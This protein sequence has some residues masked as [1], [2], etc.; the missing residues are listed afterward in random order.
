M[1][2]RVD[3]ESSRNEADLARFISQTAFNVTIP[4]LGD[5]CTMGGDCVG[6]LESSSIVGSR[7]VTSIA[8]DRRDSIFVYLSP[9]ARISLNYLDPF[10]QFNGTGTPSLQTTKPLYVPRCFFNL[11]CRELTP[12]PFVLLPLE[13]LHR[14]RP[15]FRRI[16]SPRHG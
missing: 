5:K 13:L 7:V 3:D 2:E 8:A 1:K 12:L 14:L 16:T 15:T 9:L 10:I 4:D 11:S 6:E